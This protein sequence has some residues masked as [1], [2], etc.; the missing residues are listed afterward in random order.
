MYT[1][2][3]PLDL[4]AL[5]AENVSLKKDLAASIL[6]EEEIRRKAKECVIPIQPKEVKFC[7]RDINGSSVKKPFS[8][9]HW[10]QICMV[11]DFVQFPC[12]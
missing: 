7:S 8:I 1:V 12:T 10:F 9:L 3:S 5:A 4:L 2:V 11:Y 6:R